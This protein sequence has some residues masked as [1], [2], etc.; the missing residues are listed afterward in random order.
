MKRIVVGVD[1]D[2]ASMAAARWAVQR[3]APHAGH[4]LVHVRDVR[5]PPPYVVGLEASD[6]AA[7]G[8]REDATRKLEELADQVGGSTR[9]EVR[10]GRPDEAL[11]EAAE[12]ADAELIVAGR[13]GDEGF[14]GGTAERLVNTATVPVLMVPADPPGEVARIRVAVDASPETPA[15][16][17]WARS[18]ADRHDARVTVVH[19]FQ[20]TFTGI[21]NLVSRGASHR[22]LEADQRESARSWL[23]DEARDAGLDPDR[24]TLEIREGDP[25]EQVVRDDAA[26]PDLLITG[27]RGPGAIQ[28]ALLGSVASSI[29]RSASS[30]VLVVR[31]G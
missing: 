15:V 29:L 4:L 7:D 19:V 20:P 27:S 8:A 6:E 18:L 30:P 1:F 10:A 14:L 13:S 17:S 16:L 23:E 11:S 28:K 21:G 24:T 26:R 3:F 25:A 12:E 2:D 31:R 22:E 9:V 5:P